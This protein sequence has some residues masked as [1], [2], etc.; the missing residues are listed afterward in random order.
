LRITVTN[1][2]SRYLTGPA[3]FFPNL[4]GGEA[5]WYGQLEAGRTYRYEAWMRQEAL[6]D[7]GRVEL[8]FH[9]MYTTIKQ[10]FLVTTQWQKFGFEFTA[11]VAPTS[12][13]H[14]MPRLNLT[15]PG[16]LWL[17]NIRLF[18]FDQP[19]EPDLDFVPSRAVLDE[20]LNAQTPDGPKGILRSMGVLLN[21][22]TM[23]GN[24]ATQ[25]VAM[26]RS[27]TFAMPQSSIHLFVVGTDL[28]QAGAVPP[29]PEGFQVTFAVSGALL[30]WNTVPAAT[31]YRVYRS[32]ES[33]FSLQSAPVEYT[34]TGNTWIDTNAYS[35]MVFYYRIAAMNDA[36]ESVPSLVALG[37]T[38]T[39]PPPPPTLLIPSNSVWRYHDKGLNLGTAWRSPNYNDQA[40]SNGVAKLGYGG[41]G[42]VTTL[43]YGPDGNNKYPTYYFRHAMVVDR[44]ADYTDL[45][46]RLIRD[47]GAIV[48]LN[49]VEVW[50]DNLPAG[51]V[52]YTTWATN[53]VSGADENL[54]FT[55]SLDPALLGDGTNV[56]AVEVHQQSATSSDVGFNFQLAAIRS[57]PPPTPPL[58]RARLD[59]SASMLTLAFTSQLGRVYTLLRSSNLVEWAQITAWLGTGG[60]LEFHDPLSPPP[61][62]RFYK[63]WTP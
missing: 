15:G 5:L 16:T 22:S 50:R 44:T 35:G 23:K 52:L 49:G 63:L 38:N 18:R 13:W 21:S 41:D 33:A 30:S 24:I 17:D 27:H 19:S 60:L 43:N 53:A 36:G 55:N 57:E 12:G 32:T 11:P 61:P 47:D 4:Q 14:G 8:T 7:N 1:A 58:I 39:T 29:T 28:P 25:Q 2:G 10:S 31:G 26:A 9:Q 62:A 40:W 20:L 51:T 59:S 37:G 42:E 46:A 48:Y 54:W 6:A 56:V 45:T 3:I 34:T